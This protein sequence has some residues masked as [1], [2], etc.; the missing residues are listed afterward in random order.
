MTSAM[1][2][3]QKVIPCSLVDICRCFRGTVCLSVCVFRVMNKSL[4]SVYWTL[5]VMF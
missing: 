3:L 2:V 5:K 4:N 1:A